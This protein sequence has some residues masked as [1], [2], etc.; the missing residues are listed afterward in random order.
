[1]IFDK[2]LQFSKDQAIGATAAS[3]DYLDLGS[4]RDIGPGEP[5]WLVLLSKAAPGGTSPTL[6][7]AIETDDNTSFSSV[8]SLWASGTL[9][10][11]ALAAGAMIV[12]PFPW[13]NERYVRVKY[14]QGGTDTPTHVMDAFLTNQ[15]PPS[16]QAYPDA[17]IV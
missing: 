14:T 16:W 2:T 15:P 6:A 5:L 3:T 12:V 10:A 17:S 4:D 13:T 7:I 8:T 9:A 11:A 1:M